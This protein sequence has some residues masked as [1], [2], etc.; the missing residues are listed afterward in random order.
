MPWNECKPGEK[1]ARLCHE[2]NL[3]G[4]FGAHAK[5]ESNTAH[6]VLSKQAHC[7]VPS[8]RSDA[9]TICPLCCR[10]PATSE[11]YELPGSQIDNETTDA[12]WWKSLSVVNIVSS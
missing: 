10:E 7:C 5:V 6:P 8:N 3:G 11:P 4:Q 12:T 1:M 9:A 2:A